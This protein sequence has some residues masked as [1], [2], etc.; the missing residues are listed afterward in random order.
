[1]DN[2]DSLLKTTLEGL[3]VPVERL[4]MQKKIKP[5]A[6]ITYQLVTSRERAFADDD[7]EAEEVT[8]RVDIYSQSDYIALLLDLK[9]A[10]KAAGFFGTSVDP[11]VFERDTGYYHV[12]VET[13]II[14]TEV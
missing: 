5:E 3:G 12:P 11:E 14:T 9:R 8:Y 7:N 6:Y 1:M 4:K 10:L 13:K 2:V